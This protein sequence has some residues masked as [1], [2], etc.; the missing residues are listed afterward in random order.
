MT[1][2]QDVLSF[3]KKLEERDFVFNDRLLEQLVKGKMERLRQQLEDAD[4]IRHITKKR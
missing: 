4:R 1:K 2:E 3:Q